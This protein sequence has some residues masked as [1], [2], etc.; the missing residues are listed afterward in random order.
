MSFYL[1]QR[2]SLR[3]QASGQGFDRWFSCHYMGS[4]EFE[5]GALPESL[6]RI[7]SARRLGVH[8]GTVSRRGVTRPVFVVGDAKKI[9]AIPDALTHWMADDYP[10]SKEMTYF[11]EQVEGVTREWHRET[12]AWWSLSDDVM[13]ALDALVADR[14]LASIGGDA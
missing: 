3:E 9:E 14:L 5:W 7:R 1:T 8:E 4:A 6:K 12:H 11:P 2:L 13:W 10:R